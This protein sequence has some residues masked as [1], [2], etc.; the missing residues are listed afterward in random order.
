MKQCLLTTSANLLVMTIS[1]EVLIKFHK[2]T[3]TFHRKYIILCEIYF[4]IFFDS[5]N[6]LMTS[7]FIDLVKMSGAES[8]V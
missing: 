6:Q 2:K 8:R 1:S 7:R 3:H 5:I 4:I